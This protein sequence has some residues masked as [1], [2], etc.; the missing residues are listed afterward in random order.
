MV[1]FVGMIGK[2]R[3][4]VSWERWRSTH[5][6]LL[7]ISIVVPTQVE[8]EW[9][10][11]EFSLAEQRPAPTAVQGR[12]SAGV[13]TSHGNCVRDER[14]MRCGCEARW[15]VSGSTVSPV[16]VGGAELTTEGLLDWS[17]V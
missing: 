4:D 14:R 9:G 11:T 8:G 1:S 13:R 17:G 12:V 5:S 7:E 3:D 15:T 6:P 2:S 16:G 10:C